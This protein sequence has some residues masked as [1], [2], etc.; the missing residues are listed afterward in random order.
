MKGSFILCCSCFFLILCIQQAGMCP[1]L[2]SLCKQ[3]H[4]NINS[5]VLLLGVAYL[6]NSGA[7]TSSCCHSKSLLFISRPLWESSQEIWRT[8]PLICFW[9]F[10]VCSLWVTERSI[11]PPS[12][13]DAVLSVSGPSVALSPTVPHFITGAPL[14]LYKP[15]VSVSSS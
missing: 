12:L 7:S 3:G 1:G 13:T 15:Q 10:D 4:V 6:H 8:K 5:S 14:S 2:G 11:S 9:R